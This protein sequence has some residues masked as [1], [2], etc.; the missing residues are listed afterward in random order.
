M[1]RRV[2]MASVL[3]LAALAS[4]LAINTLR[5]GSR[6]TA[7][8]PFP[9]IPVDSGAAS[10]R[11]AGAVRFRTISFENP[12]AETQA[13]LL[14]FRAYLER[15]FP[16]LHAALRREIVN[17]YS[18]L[19][20]WPGEDSKARPILLMA[21]QDVVP[22][23][24]GTEKDWHAEPFSGEIRDGF[25]W[26]RGS[27]DDKGNLMAIL[28]AVESLAA[29]G[30]RP[31]RTIYLAFGH[32]EENGGAEGASMIAKLLAGRGVHCE[33]ALDEGLLITEGM[34]PGL[35][36]PAALIGIAEKGSVTLR[37]TA[38]A[39]PGHSSMP[40]ARSAIGALATAIERVQ[41]A[42]M[43]ASI[44]GVTAKMFDAIAPEL[45]GFKRVAMSN[46]WLFGP[47]VRRQL[48]ASPPTN[49]LVRTT[50]AVTVIRGG[51]KDNV[52]PGEAEAL[53]NF[54]LLPGDSAD[55]VI[56]HVRGAVQDEHI[57]IAPAYPA[58]EP[59]PVASVSS[60]SYQLID[61]T[62]REVFPGTIVAPGLMIAATDSRHMT[63]VADDIYRFSPVRAHSEDLLRFHG[64]DE[65]MAVSNYVELI[66]FYGELIRNAA[67]RD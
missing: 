5:Q 49:A 56:K 19:F 48:E 35:N 54:R 20:T 42:P 43:P 40:P 55:R 65:R 50:M 29:S 64:T 22:I 15:S 18:L 52:L 45:T 53:I 60:A 9:L 58:D 21:H 27:W 6:Q 8:L 3:I 38:Y 66:R 11:L 36:P 16:H 12:S 7:A 44:A 37:L 10:A 26:G 59:S 39:T 67:G 41:A 25:I 33:F 28:E 51:D 1:I 47:L 17:G 63:A 13:Q 4:A 61:R 46:L 57:R 23:S 30:F 14:E 62:I 32:D 31:R 2:L 34:L 24:P